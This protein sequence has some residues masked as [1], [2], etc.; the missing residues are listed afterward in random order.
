VPEGVLDLEHHGAVLAPRARLQSDGQVEDAHPQHV[1]DLL[2]RHRARVDHGVVQ[3]V[4]VQ[5]A[6]ADHRDQVHVGQELPQPEVGGGGQRDQVVDVDAVLVVGV[7]LLDAVVA[8]PVGTTVRV[9]VQHGREHP[10][11]TAGLPVERAVVDLLVERRTRDLAPGAGQV[12][13][14]HLACQRVGV[15]RLDHLQ[16]AGLGGGVVTQPEP[17]GPH[18][19]LGR[20]VAG[21]RAESEAAVDRSLRH[22]QGSHG[23]ACCGGVGQVLAHQ[24][25]EQTATAVR[26]RDGHVGDHPQR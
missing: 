21:G 24:L 12:R 3:R 19:D 1:D 4:V 23:H 15:L 10:V 11:R 18:V 17:A 16:G 25:R 13:G 5:H 8:V 14:V 2:G 26:R 6:R 9:E 22:R 7:A 20:A